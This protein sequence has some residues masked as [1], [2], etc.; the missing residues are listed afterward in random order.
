MLSFFIVCLLAQQSPTTPLQMQVGD[1]QLRIGGFLDAMV[2]NRSTATGNGI[3]TSF[4]TIPFGNTPQGNLSETKLSAQNSRLSMQATSP[5]GEVKVK[6]YVEVDFT[7]NAPNALNVTSNGNTL[8]MRLYWAQITSG[9][10][11]FLAGQSWSLLTP[12]RTGL[13]PVPADVFF[14]QTVDTNYQ[15]GLT[16]TRAMQFRFIAHPSDALAAGV[17]L[18]NP[19]QYVGSAVVLP[20]GFPA[21]EVDNGAVTTTT[22]NRYPDIIGKIAF[23]P[24]TGKTHQHVEASVVL[25]G[26]K[27][28]NP[29]ST[30][31]FTATGTGVEIAANVEPIPNLHVLGS[32][33]F[34]DG[35]GRYIANVNGP[36]FIVNPD[37]SLN[38]VGSRSAIG[39]AEYT[40]KKTLVYGYFSYAAFDQ[41]VATQSDGIII[42][43]GVPNSTAANHTLHETTIGV[44]HTIFRDAKAGALQ[45]MGQYSNVARTPFAAPSGTPDH[46]A[47]N[48]V[49]LNVRYL[50]P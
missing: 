10:F 12:N 26:F 14:S 31:T 22:P 1:A 39:G 3:A 6:G 20:T 30:Q 35:G 28:V 19:E 7:G 2:V 49:Y 46:A 4:G 33:Y 5:L 17:A 44:T 16:W 43:F 37:S 48:M 34:S 32:G 8:R 27:T 11:E 36:D 50:L 38:V 18:E 24:K 42:G 41:Q 29:A 13:S 47:V 15:M 9:R 25:R 45:V 40:Y 21:F 23:D